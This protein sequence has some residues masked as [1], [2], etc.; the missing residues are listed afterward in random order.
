MDEGV[1]FWCSGSKFVGGPRDHDVGCI[2]AAAD[3]LAVCAVAKSLLVVKIGDMKDDVVGG[4]Y[5]LDRLL[6][7]FILESTAGARPCED[8]HFDRLIG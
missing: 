7:Y 1:A 8:G 2:C 5:L 4:E 6:C 3:F